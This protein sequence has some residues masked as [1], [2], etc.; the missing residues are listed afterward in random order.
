MKNNLGT[1]GEIISLKYLSHK[2]YQ[3]LFKNFHSRYGELDLIAKKDDV[4]VV[5]E[6]KTRTNT[7]FQ[8]IQTAISYSKQ[9]KISLAVMDFIQRYPHY[10]D[11]EIHLDIILCN[12]NS[13]SNEFSVKHIENAFEMLI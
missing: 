3:I 6:V 7:P 5:V 9:R 11:F 2:G 10:E 12:Y 13:E 8:Q 4:L 1:R